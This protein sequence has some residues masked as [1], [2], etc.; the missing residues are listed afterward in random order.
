[1]RYHLH[2]GAAVQGASSA[3]R[4][5]DKTSRT[6]DCKLNVLN[7]FRG[8]LI[9]NNHECYL[10]C[11]HPYLC[12]QTGARLDPK[13]GVKGLTPMLCQFLCPRHQVK[14]YRC[15]RV[16]GPLCAPQVSLPED[17][18]W[19]PAGGWWD[20]CNVP[21]ADVFAVV[22]QLADLYAMPR[23]TYV[24]VRAAAAAAG[25]VDL[26][27]TPPTIAAAADSGAGLGSPDGG[28]VRRQAASAEEGAV[29]D[30]G[31]APSSLLANGVADGGG[32]RG[33]DDGDT[34]GSRSEVH[35]ALSCV[36]VGHTDHFG[37]GCI[38]ELSDF[39]SIVC[40]RTCRHTQ[41][42]QLS[43]DAYACKNHPRMRG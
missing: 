24:D 21:R 23:A 2:G 41:S 5:P 28:S 27:P 36:V 38:F 35:L 18:D 12:S 14:A 20:L 37:C 9:V 16:R 30:G 8:Q 6:A 19:C 10:C 4:D 7:N 42:C 25:A 11:V 39:S 34:G 17:R 13:H 15:C 40:L 31:S 29:Q 43:S 3:T 33:G 1:M 32:R 26:S 22:R